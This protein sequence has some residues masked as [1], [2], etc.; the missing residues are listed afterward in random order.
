MNEDAAD[1]LGLSLTAELAVV[2]P[3][4]VFRW[5]QWLTFS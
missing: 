1:V 5:R 4:I 2:M 3:R